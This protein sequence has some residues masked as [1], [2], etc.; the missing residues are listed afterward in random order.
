MWNIQIFVHTTGLDL[1]RP[2]VLACFRRE[3]CLDYRSTAHSNVGRAGCGATTFFKVMFLVKASCDDV[4]G[5]KVPP[6]EGHCSSGVGK[7]EKIIAPKRPGEEEGAAQVAC[8]GGAEDVCGERLVAGTGGVKK[9]V[10]LWASGGTGI[11][12]ANLRRELVG[13]CLC[14]Q[15]SRTSIAVTGVVPSPYRCM[16]SAVSLKGFTTPAARRYS[17]GGSTI[18]LIGRFDKKKKNTVCTTN[19]ARK[20]K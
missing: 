8:T 1:P 13:G 2:S 4:T 17:S 12:D 7:E 16:P 20:N 5:N 9:G 6:Q 3:L 10:R 18:N 15:R 19:A 11:R 14:C